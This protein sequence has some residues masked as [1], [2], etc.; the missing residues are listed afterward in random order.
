MLRWYAIVDATGHRVALLQAFDSSAALSAVILA[1]R[2]DSLP[3]ID[4]HA[5]DATPDEI[6][7]RRVPTFTDTRKGS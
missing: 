4:L 1:R 3:S 2:R 7:Q 5:R 6:P